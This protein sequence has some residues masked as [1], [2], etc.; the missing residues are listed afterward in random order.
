MIKEDIL[1]FEKSNCDCCL[2]ENINIIKCTSN[3]KCEY[4]M[5]ANCMSELRLITKTNKCPN[6]RET[7]IEIDLSSDEEKELPPVSLSQDEDTDSDYDSET[8]EVDL[9]RLNNCERLEKGLKCI[10]IW[11]YYFIAVTLQFPYITCAEYYECIFGCYDIQCLR[12]NNTKKKIIVLSTMI[13]LIIIAILLGCLTHAVVIG[14]NPLILIH[15]KPWIFLLQSFI[16]LVLLISIIT[17]IVIV[18][19]CIYSCCFEERE[20]Y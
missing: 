3:N 17:A 15:Y 18:L 4:A 12:Y 7:K 20:Y 9:D 13:L 1:L 19:M 11:I 6:C 14:T 2:E 10:I 5:C 16:G 8:D